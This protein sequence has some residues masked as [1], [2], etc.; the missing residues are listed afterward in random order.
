MMTYLTLFLC[1][2]QSDQFYNAGW[3]EDLRR[4]INYV[5]EKYPKAPIFTIGTSIGANIVVIAFILL[6][7]NEVIC[8]GI[9]LGHTQ[10]PHILAMTLR[11]C[12]MRN[13]CSCIVNVTRIRTKYVGLH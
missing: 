2:V 12:H 13:R 4:I 3:T 5:H 9:R 8:T 10:Q 7:F 6:F 11:G 1:V